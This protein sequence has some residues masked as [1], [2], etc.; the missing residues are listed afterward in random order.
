MKKK[1]LPKE[2]YLHNTLDAGAV[3]SELKNLFV[4]EK[5]LISLIPVFLTL[6][7]LPGGQF[8]QR[9]IAVNIPID[10]NQQ[11]ALLP[12]SCARQSSVLISFERPN[13][14]PVT[15]PVRLPVLYRALLWLQRNNHLYES[16]DISCLPATFSDLTS[17]DMENS[18]VSTDIVEEEFGLTMKDTLVSEKIHEGQSNEN[19]IC[20]IPVATQKPVNLKDH[21]FGEEKAFPWLFSNRKK[22]LGL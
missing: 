16:I 7:I 15:L 8:A 4:V 17:I 13:N 22:W 20:T 19:S 21:P 11:I 2:S 3:P 6:I 5:R 9:G 14:E 12:E 1:S 18:S 10:I